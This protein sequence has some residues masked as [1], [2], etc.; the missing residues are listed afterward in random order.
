MLAN[1]DNPETAFLFVT[2]ERTPL[3]SRQRIAN[4][5][6]AAECRTTCASI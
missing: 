3:N 4:L 5:E 2:V 6:M 1:S